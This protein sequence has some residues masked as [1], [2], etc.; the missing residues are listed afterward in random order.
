MLIKEKALSVSS[1]YLWF[2]Y[3]KSMSTK[4]NGD[5]DL[6]EININDKNGGKI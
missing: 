2:S 1:D 6:C 3:V 5:G 4:S